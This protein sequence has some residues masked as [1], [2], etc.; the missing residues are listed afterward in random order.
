MKKSIIVLSFIFI[1]AIAASGFAATELKDPVAVQNIGF[2]AYEQGEVELAEKLFNK[3]IEL[4]PD[5]EHAR[6][7]L[8]VLLHEQERYVEAIEQLDAL[9]QIDDS[10][11]EYWYDMGVNLIAEFRVEEEVENFYYGIEAYEQAAAIDNDYA[12]V[13][14]NLEVLYNLKTMLE[15]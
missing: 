4:D 6:T 10:N 8:A 1:A 2:Y 7:D 15:S 3:A 13:Q 5:Y 12:H 9:V 11:P 14:E